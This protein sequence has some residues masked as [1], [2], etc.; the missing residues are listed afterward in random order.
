MLFCSTIQ[1]NKEMIVCDE[2]ASLPLLVKK[3]DNDNVSCRTRGMLTIDG[4]KAF[5]ARLDNPFE[6]IE[7]IYDAIERW[8]LVFSIKS[9]EPEDYLHGYRC[10]K[11]TPGL[12][13]NI[14]DEH[15]QARKVFNGGRI[16]VGLGISGGTADTI[17]DIL[18]DTPYPVIP[19]SIDSKSERSAPIP[20]TVTSDNLLVQKMETEKLE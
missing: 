10:L 18:S 1:F 12:Y 17:T 7:P 9:I 16:G 20:P 4:G 11:H 8:T 13:V 15:E 5:T 19:H 2:G 6:L 14:E 3:L